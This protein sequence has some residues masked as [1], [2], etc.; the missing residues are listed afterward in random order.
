MAGQLTAGRCY[1]CGRPRPVVPGA[2]AVL[3]LEALAG[4]RWLG[5]LCATCEGLP[6]AAW[7]FVDAARRQS[8]EAEIAR[9]AVV[10]EV[11]RSTPL[12]L[13]SP[14]PGEWSAMSPFGQAARARH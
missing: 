3:G 7:A 5:W 14:A 1:H 10:G 9:T 8:P 13:P 6:G 12:V 2:V 4:G 11:V